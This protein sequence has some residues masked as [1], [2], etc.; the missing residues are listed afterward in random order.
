MELTFQNV[1]EIQPITALNG[2]IALD[3]VRERI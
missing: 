3:Y 2:R 1:F